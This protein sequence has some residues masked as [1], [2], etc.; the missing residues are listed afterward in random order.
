M[1]DNGERS[2]RDY[3]QLD[4]E[5]LLEELGAALLGTGPGFGPSDIERKARYAQCW[6]AQRTDDFCRDVCG[7]VWARLE[8]GGGFDTLTD[9]AIVADALQAAFGRPTANIVAVILL[10]RGLGELCD[11]HT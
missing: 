11:K 6:L 9:A 1:V 8:H 5:N 7:E 4:D 3:L 10:R 2:I